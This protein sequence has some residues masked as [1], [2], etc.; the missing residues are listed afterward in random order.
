M[1]G[2][3]DVTSSVC[4]CVMWVGAPQFCC[5]LILL[6]NRNKLPEVT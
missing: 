4:V 2:V 5:S 3:M 6:V 1:L